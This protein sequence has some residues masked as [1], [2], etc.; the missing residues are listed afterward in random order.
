MSI[1]TIKHWLQV[2]LRI[3]IVNQPSKFEH[4]QALLVVQATARAGIKKFSP[5]TRPS[6]AEGTKKSTKTRRDE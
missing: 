4:K 3:S 5:M 6:A 1:L 2:P